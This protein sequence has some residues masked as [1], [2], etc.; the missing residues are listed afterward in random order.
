MKE[1]SVVYYT[2]EGY[3]VPTC[4]SALS[5]LEHNPDINV[6][7]WIFCDDYDN[8]KQDSKTI[9]DSLQGDSF[10]E[11]TIMST[12]ALK[13]KCDYYKLPTY[14]GAQGVFLKMFMCDWIPDKGCN[15]LFLDGDTL[16]TGKLDELATYM[17]PDGCSCAAMI[18]TINNRLMKRMLHMDEASTIFC[19]AT[20]LVSPSL[21]KL[22]NSAGRIDKW[23]NKIAR[24]GHVEQIMLCIINEQG[25]L[26]KALEKQCAI[27]PAKYMV[28]A[29]NSVLKHK[30]RSILFGLQ[31]KEYYLNAD[32]DCANENPIIIHYMHYI[33]QKP[34]KHDELNR[35]E[36]LWLDI[37]NKI[38]GSTIFPVADW[39]MN[40]VEKIKRVLVIHTPILFAIIG[41]MYLK[42]NLKKSIRYCDSMHV[43]D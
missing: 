25:V 7:F 11:V 23:L 17:F 18:D 27:L 6:Y 21:W 2:D 43:F 30:Y 34:W 24:I 41:N 40:R 29:G 19:H 12:K 10:C 14:K 42:H 38:D 26:S 22:Y 16:V 36:K 28:L 32:I 35:Y 8:W 4:T 1:L 37:Y 20:F 3:I 15:I 31:D 9:I 39:K 33:V 13:E 5:L